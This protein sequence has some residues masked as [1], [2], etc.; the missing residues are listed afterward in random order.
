[1]ALEKT[2]KSFQELFKSLIRIV[3]QV[4]TNVL[5][6]SIVTITYQISYQ[7]I[8]LVKGDRVFLQTIFR[9]LL[10]CHRLDGG[11]SKLLAASE[12]LKELNEKLEIQKVAV[13]EKSEACEKLLSEIQRATELANEKKAMAV[14]KREEIA[15][16]NKE[17]VVEKA[18]AEEALAQA[19][20][21]LEEAKLA[22]QD[23]DK[24]D[25]T[26]IRYVF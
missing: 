1:M 26:E 4:S 16:Q 24:S 6:C 5:Y 8:L 25:V 17:I 18:E 15:E 11:L 23:L 20:P 7:I 2:W 9:L 13:T 3:F 14:G 10:Q 12:Q 21:A 19:L 22:L